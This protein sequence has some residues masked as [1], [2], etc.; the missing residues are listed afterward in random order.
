M[1]LIGQGY[2][3]DQ[4]TGY[5]LSATSGMFILLV[6]LLVTPGVH[7]YC[8]SFYWSHREYIHIACRSIGHTRSISI[9]LVVLLVTRG[10]YP[11]CLSFYWSHVKH[12]PVALTFYWSHVEFIPD[13]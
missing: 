3:Y 4:T 13:A 1:D 8:L 12:I 7:P 9:L 2:N 5:Y 11:Y 6:V 10:V